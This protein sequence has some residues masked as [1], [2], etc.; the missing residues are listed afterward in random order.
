MRSIKLWSRFRPWLE[1]FK[2]KNVERPA[3]VLQA[4]GPLLVADRAVDVM[5][6]VRVCKY[7][8]H[9]RNLVFEKVSDETEGLVENLV[10]GTLG[11]RER[12]HNN[13]RV[14]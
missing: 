4:L 10:A 5:E 14:A 8:L 9:T 6:V 13:D 1:L 7:V 2:T 11:L 12:T 3:D